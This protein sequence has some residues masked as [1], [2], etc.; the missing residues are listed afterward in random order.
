MRK[1]DK[2]IIAK[3]HQHQG[4]LFILLYFHIFE[5][6]AHMETLKND[7]YITSFLYCTNTHTTLM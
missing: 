4:N 1:D 7:K 3:H 2:L 6:Y 5:T